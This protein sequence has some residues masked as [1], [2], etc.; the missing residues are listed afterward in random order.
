MA[1]LLTIRT[2]RFKSLSA[3]RR[4]ISRAPTFDPSAMTTSSV[5][6]VDLVRELVAVVCRAREV[7]L[8]LVTCAVDR[9]DDAIGE[10]SCLE[11]DGQLRRDLVPEA[12]RHLLIETA[13]TED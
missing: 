4:Y 2:T 6:D 13:V 1:L 3:R 9:V 11:A 10:F 7:G 8:E 5:R 12:S